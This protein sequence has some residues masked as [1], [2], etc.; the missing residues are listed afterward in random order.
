MAIYS[1]NMSIVGRN[2][3]GGRP[4]NAIASAAYVSREVLQDER[5]GKYFDFRAKGGV[6]FA[7]IFTPKGAPEWMQDRQEL[8]N[9]VEE[10]AD[11]SQRPDRAQTARRFILALPHE[12]N[13]TQ[14]LWLTKDFARSLARQGMVVDFAIHEPDAHAEGEGKKNYHVHMLLTMR[15]VTAD[16]FGGKLKELDKREAALEW[17]ERWAHMG[18]KALERAGYAEEARRY[19]YSHLTLKAQRSEATRQGDHEHAEHLNRKP[20]RHMGPRA[21]AME[22][23]GFETDKG[24][25]NR[26]I[27]EKNAAR[28]RK[29][30]PLLTPEAQQVARDVK[31]AVRQNKHKLARSYAKGSEITGRV[32]FGTVLGGIADGF[33]SLLASPATP[34]K[35]AAALNAIRDREEAERQAQRNRDRG[36]D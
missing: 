18:A 2:P 11:D 8:W 6:E 20:T 7:G 32:L 24:F 1:F 29:H 33:S 4:G 34:E 19:E 31:S 23:E 36:R 21:S 12:L 13:A 17:R 3:K 28:H 5:T 30:E 35:D 26:A 9:R 25:H 22:R 14:R 16:G 15:E 27:K 10:R